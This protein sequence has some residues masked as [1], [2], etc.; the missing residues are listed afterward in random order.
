VKASDGLYARSFESL[1]TKFPKLTP[2]QLR[3][4]VL[5]KEMVPSWRIAEML[6]I[7]E[8]TV[9]NHRYKAH[10]RMSGAVGISLYD[11]LK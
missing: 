9:E 11:A 10:A 5:V 6:G 7:S 1:T 3:V 2:M 4:C 8:K